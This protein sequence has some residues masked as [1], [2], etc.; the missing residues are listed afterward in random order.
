MI[1]LEGGWA[2]ISINS[3]EV[4]IASSPK[5]VVVLQLFF[6]FFFFGCAMQLEGS[7]FPDQGLNLGPE[8]E[9]AKS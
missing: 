2:Y 7:Y 8:S 1:L 9:R 4:K 6:F 5:C 3:S